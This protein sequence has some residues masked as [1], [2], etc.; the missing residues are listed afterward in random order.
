MNQQHLQPNSENQ[1]VALGRVL[2]T[3]REEENA[4][5]LIETTLD[6]LK[7]ELNYRLIWIGLYDRLEHR[8]CGK[9]GSTPTGDTTFLNQW[10]DLNPGDLLEQV[11]IQQR[12]VGIP[13]LRQEPRA[14]EWRRAAQDFE[15]QGTLLFPLRCK[16]RCFGVVLL[17]S[18]RWGVSPR[19]AEKALLSSLLGGLA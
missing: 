11:V 6:Y 9:G 17:G 18:H 3:L 8:L 19:T 12:P 5:V 13:D 4:D 10:F 15:V 16:D 14:G 1:L 2:Q 7:T